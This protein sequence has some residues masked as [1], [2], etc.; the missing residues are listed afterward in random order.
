MPKTRP[1]F[2]ALTPSITVRDAKRAIE[3]Y[4]DALGAKVNGQPFLM[5][6][7]S[8]MHAE[9]QFA[10]SVLMLNDEMPQH[11][12]LSPLGHDN[13]TAVTLHLY[14]DDVDAVFKKAVEKGATPTMPVADQF[15]GDRFG[16]I[17]DPFGHSWGLAT[18]LREMSEAEM[19]AAMKRGPGA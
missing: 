2:R 7:G 1:G 14:V 8:V 13:K 10:D 12:V 5:P 4:K 16:S 19:V 18:H 11:G 9:L 3:W 15:W 6:D 17:K